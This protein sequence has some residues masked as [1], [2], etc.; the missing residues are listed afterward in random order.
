LTH[1]RRV[2]I[3]LSVTTSLIK[4]SRSSDQQF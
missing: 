1:E 3:F 4:F 2:V